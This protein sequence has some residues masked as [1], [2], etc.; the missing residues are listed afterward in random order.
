MNFYAVQAIYRYEMART[1]RTLFQSV[2]SPV[3]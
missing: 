3:I 1:V 2:V